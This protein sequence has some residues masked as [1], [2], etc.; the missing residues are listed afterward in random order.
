VGLFVSQADSL[1][2]KYAFV[3]KY[4]TIVFGYVLIILGILVF[5]QQINRIASFEYLINLV[6]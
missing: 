5:T 6:F 4:I 2:R 3:A 1:I